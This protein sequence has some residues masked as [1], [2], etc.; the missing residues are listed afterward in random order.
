MA[1][2]KIDVSK[3][4]GFEQMSA[5]DKV[6]ALMGY[7]FEDYSDEL[8]A[9]KDALDKQKKATDNA[10]SQAADFKKQLRE[11]MSADE[12]AEADRV[13]ELEKLR[14]ENESYKRDSKIAE[15]KTT[16]L[17]MGYDETLATKRAVAIFDGDFATMN[18]IDKQFLEAHDK[19]MHAQSVANTTTP[20]AGGKGG[21]TTITA[22]QFKKMGYSER[23][24]LKESNPELYSELSK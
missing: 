2:N 18:A 4:D 13:A 6:K 22:E 24:A 14:A 9:T 12:Q 11:K 10:C 15:Y 16:A 5:E 23:V 21:S 20:P 17:A 8:K 7:E 19:A 3:I 1:T